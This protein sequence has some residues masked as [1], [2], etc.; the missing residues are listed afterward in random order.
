MS[1]ITEVDTTDRPSDWPLL[2]GMKFRLHDRLLGIL[3]LDCDRGYVL[4]SYDF[5]MPTVRATTFPNALDDG[6]YDVTKYVGERAVNLEITLKARA[7]VNDTGPLIAPESQLRDKLRAYL[8]PGRRPVLIFSEH[9][10]PRCRL[11]LLRGADSSIAV[12]QP[13]YNAMS[14]SW[15]APR[16]YIESYRVKKII[17]TIDNVLPEPLTWTMVNEGNAPAYWS[18]TVLGESVKPRFAIHNFVTGDHFLKLDYSTQS[19]NDVV[20][21]DSYTHTVRINGRP[22]GYRYVDDLSEW[23]RIPPGESTFELWFDELPRV[24]YPY[25]TWTA[26]VHQPPFTPTAEQG[27]WTKRAADIP[28][29]PDPDPAN[30]AYAWSTRPING[31]TPGVAQIEFRFADT[32]M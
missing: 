7:S 3:D 19:P 29:Q 26:G 2:G 18:A 13:R 20:E 12:A 11:I 6:I 22:V 31:G 5:S 9:E 30:A 10:D 8:H 15:V 23:W 24:G 32:W 28:P 25:G 21:I 4:R 16:S 27:I 1:S 17:S 14:V